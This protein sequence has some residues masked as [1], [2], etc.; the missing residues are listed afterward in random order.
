MISEA[1]S[2]GVFIGRRKQLAHLIAR[3]K[4]A[5]SGHGSIVLVAGEPGIGKTRLMEEFAATLTHGRCRVFWWRCDEFAAANFA[6]LVQKV[7]DGAPRAVALFVEDAQWASRETLE[8]LVAL[9]RHVEATRS[10]VVV[11]Y[12]PAEVEVDAERTVLLGKLA[13]LSATTTIDLPPLDQDETK[14]LTRSLL[15]EGNSL[16]RVALETIERRSGGHPVL[17]LEM[18][19]HATRSTSAGGDPSGFPLSITGMVAE[20][21]RPFSDADRRILEHGALMREGFTAAEVAALA[22]ASL[23]D[24]AATLRRSLALRLIVERRD[25]AGAYAFRQPIVGEILEGNFLAHES[26][27][28][29]AKIAHAIESAGDVDRRFAELARHWAAAGNDEMAASYAEKAGD[30][31]FSASEFGDAAHW[32]ERAAGLTR[33]AGRTPRDVYEKLGTRSSVRATSWVRRAHCERPPRSSKRPE[34]STARSVCA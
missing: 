8:A 18:V 15:V 26:Q 27:A 11:T 10:L 3:R 19:R 24:V 31:A 13:R 32:Y 33:R 20:W 30:R 12:R 6:P 5:A 2:R 21:L 29:H 23:A 25:A 9:G 17:L 22:G 1:K 28:L 7:V 4:A 34:K 14:A 16:G